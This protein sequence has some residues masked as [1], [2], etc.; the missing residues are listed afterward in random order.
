MKLPLSPRANR[1]LELADKRARLY[2]WDTLRP[3]HILLGILDEKES[4]AAGV[5]ESL[6]PAG[7]IERAIAFIEGR[8]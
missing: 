8:K 5:L 6:V 1:V 4:I 7:Q 2:G 3:E